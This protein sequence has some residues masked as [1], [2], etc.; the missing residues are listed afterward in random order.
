[1]KSSALDYVTVFSSLAENMGLILYCKIVWGLGRV[2]GGPLMAPED[3]LCV[4][5]KLLCLFPEF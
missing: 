5:K 2:G 3:V 4:S 1:M